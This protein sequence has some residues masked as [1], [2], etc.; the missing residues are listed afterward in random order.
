M[1]SLEQA[2]LILAIGIA[3][4]LIGKKLPIEN[5]VNTVLYI[6]GIVLVVVGIIFL[7]LALL[8]PGLFILPT[9]A[10]TTATPPLLLLA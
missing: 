9:T 2:I 1:A 7:L 6:I 5:T 4:A 8:G 10:M 3:L